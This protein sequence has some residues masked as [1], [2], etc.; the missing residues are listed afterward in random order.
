LAVLICSAQIFIT[1]AYMYEKAG[2]VAPIMYLQIIICCLAD[3]MLFG[4]TLTSN[5]IIGGALIVLTNF[6]IALFKALGVI[7]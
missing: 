5:Q 7:S 2:R 4:T 6:T 3:I 1:E